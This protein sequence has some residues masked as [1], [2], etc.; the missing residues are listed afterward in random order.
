M[1][2]APLF[3]RLTEVVSETYEERT[4]AEP[5][6]PLPNTSEFD[7]G[8]FWKAT[9]DKRLTYQVC[10]DCGAVNFYPR[11][12]CISCLGNSLT[13]RD[14]SGR[15]KVYS[16]SVIRQSYHPFFRNVVPYAV[17]WIDLEEGPRLLSNVVGVEDPLQDI[18]IDMPV[19][20]EWEEHEDVCIPLFRPA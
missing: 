3:W 11:R 18:S 6:R 12:H 2:L 19:M 20:V 14:A 13:V 17:A 16:F 9:R 10:D 5:T 8:P 15:G 1:R 7:T 4:M